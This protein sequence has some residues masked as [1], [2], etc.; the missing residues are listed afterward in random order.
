MDIRTQSRERPVLRAQQRR[1]ELG[2]AR[3]GSRLAP[4]EANRQ[5]RQSLKAIRVNPAAGDD[6]PDGSA[7]GARES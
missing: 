2:L 4:Q 6:A 1:L 7:S 3:L 5:A